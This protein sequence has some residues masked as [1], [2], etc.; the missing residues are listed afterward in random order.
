LLP[1]WRSTSEQDWV[2]CENNQAG[3]LNG[4]YEPGPLSKQKEAGLEK[5]FKWYFETMFR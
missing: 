1:F 3:I 2:L 4:R 5:F